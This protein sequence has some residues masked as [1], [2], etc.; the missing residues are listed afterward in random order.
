MKEIQT[1]H[2]MYATSAEKQRNRRLKHFPNSN[3]ALHNPLSLS[4]FSVFVFLSSYSIS[5]NSFF[6]FIFRQLT[7][8]RLSSAFS[9]VY[10]DSANFSPISKASD[11]T[12]NEDVTTLLLEEASTENMP[13]DMMSSEKITEE[14]GNSSTL[15]DCFGAY[16]LDS[17][18]FT[19]ADEEIVENSPRNVQPQVCNSIVADPRYR[20]AVDEITKNVMEELYGNIQLGDSNCVDRVLDEKNVMLFLCLCIWIVVVFAVFFFTSDICCPPS[21]HVPT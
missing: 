19:F 4:S 7:K 13:S 15:T 17:A 14:S 16:E 18:M 3:L 20:Q 5:Y 21:G 2:K 12:H 8:K 10:E 9:S 11:A 6:V 1:P